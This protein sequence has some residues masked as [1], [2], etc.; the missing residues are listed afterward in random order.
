MASRRTP[1][2]KVDV[3]IAALSAEQRDQLAEMGR[4]HAN[5]TDI[6]R[7]LNGQG[8]EVAYHS[9]L[10]WYN[11]EY[12]VGD[13][14]QQMNALIA[15]SRGLNLTDAHAASLC[16]VVKLTDQIMG[17]LTEQG[18]ENLSP[19][20]LSNLVDLLREQRQSAQMLANAKQLGD[21]RG[22]E[23]A[24]GYRLAEISVNLTRDTPNAE[25]VKSVVDAAL[26]KLEEE[27]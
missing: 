17:K 18:I 2:T 3:A 20:L 9:V 26:A 6:H 19:S 21:R 11:R 16:C 13:E 4:N 7:W 12:P 15:G 10:S 22:L 24:G 1:Q 8:C 23:L 14:A 27:V 5:A 25:T